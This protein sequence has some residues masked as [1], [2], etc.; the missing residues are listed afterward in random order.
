MAL[1]LFN[2]RALADASPEF[3]KALPVRHRVCFDNGE[4]VDVWSNETMYSYLFW[5]LFK[6]YPVARM[7]KQHHVHHTLKDEALTTDTHS[8]L[9]TEILK[10][11]VQEADLR[12]PA[13]KE[14]LLSAIYQSI[15]EAMAA[16]SI[17]CESDVVS[18]DI[19][20]FIQIARHPAIEALRL[21]AMADPKRIKYVY[22][23]TI[24]LIETLPE[25]IENGLAKAVK[26][27]MVK[28]NQVV[29]CVVF[30]G[31]STEVDGTIFPE[32][33]WGNYTFGMRKFYDFMSDSRLAAKSH[34]YSDTA[35]KDSEY[36][37]RRFQLFAMPLER[38]VHQDCGTKKH[39]T[40]LVKGRELDNSG[41]VV[42]AGDLP[43]LVGKHYLEEGSTVYKTIKG[44]EEHLVGTYIKLRTILG[45]EAENP[46]TVCHVCVGD[47]SQNISRFTNLGHLGSVSI[48]K[49]FTQNILSIKHVNT[50]SMVLKV[51]LGENERRYLNTG[52]E[53]TAF[54]LNKEMKKLKPTLTILR[55]EAPGLMD[56]K[57][58]QNIEQISLA[59]IS[60]ATELL[61]RVESGKAGVQYETPL[62]VQQKMKTSMLS[63][64]FLKY[65]QKVGWDV[66]DKNNFVFD[67]AA[68]DYADPILVMMNKEESFVDLANQADKLVQSS[69]KLI[70]NRH[71]ENAPDVLLAELFDLVNSKL[72]VNILAFEMVIYPLMVKSTTSY[73][74][75]RRI[76]N[77]V[78]GVAELL[79]KFRSMGAALAYEDQHEALANPANFFQGRRPDSPMDVFMTPHEVVAAEKHKAYLY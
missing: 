3:I 79:T 12:L 75:A 29:Q 58:I 11:I 9:C 32:P 38:I 27:K 69:Q 14:P 44:N 30:R 7:L 76:D 33:V 40:W 53:G 64:E 19:L 60:A 16:L 63:R 17:L 25:F 70:K 46:H 72:R 5:G 45:C 37:A 65:L 13:Q 34:F 28:A 23:E 26:S 77:P 52:A 39:T 4:I 57:N 15:S 54:Y 61:I 31:Y 20:D 41:T 6:P 1:P 51:L 66:D 21:D 8:K 74:M 67:M 18:I 22:E 55:D 2:I 24:R 68:W 56:L 50:S 42:Y 59:R 78:L 10:T 36:T 62:D 47:L 35:L 71:V 73:E 49:E 48:T 43:F